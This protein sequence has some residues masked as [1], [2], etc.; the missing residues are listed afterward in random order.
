MPFT[1]I[2][3]QVTLEL[4]MKVTAFDPEEMLCDAYEPSL[5]R[6]VSPPDAA[7]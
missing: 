4:P 5:I 2:D 7:E 1:L 3:D 6:M